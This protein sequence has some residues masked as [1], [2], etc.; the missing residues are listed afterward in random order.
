[1]L[2]PARVQRGSV[3]RLR[4]FLHP[5]QE[6]AICVSGLRFEHP[7]FCCLYFLARLGPH[8]SCLVCACDVLPVWTELTTE[9]V[10]SVVFDAQASIF[11]SPNLI[12]VVVCLLVD[13]YR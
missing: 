7:I 10:S 6:R 12:L 2:R 11:S 3:G 9:L 8:I 1:M 13:C 4:L 5:A